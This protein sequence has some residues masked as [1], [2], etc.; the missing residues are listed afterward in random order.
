MTH[1]L[2]WDCGIRSPRCQPARVPARAAEA[3]NVAAVSFITG[4]SL[5]LCKCGLNLCEVTF[6]APN[7]SSDSTPRRACRCCIACTRRPQFRSSPCF[8]I[9]WKKKPSTDRQFFWRGLQRIHSKYYCSLA[10]S[11]YMPINNSPVWSPRP[12][13]SLVTLDMALQLRSRRSSWSLGHNSRLQ[14][15]DFLHDHQRN[16]ENF[17]L[18]D[19]ELHSGGLHL[20]HNTHGRVLV[21]VEGELDVAAMAIAAVVDN[22]KP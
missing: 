18:R 11:P 15:P 10:P 21:D 22:A 6:T 5:N 9:S 14:S 2:R 13:S 20:T 8:L 3:Q 12:L 4:W 1:V 19:L 16:R 17:L 7:S